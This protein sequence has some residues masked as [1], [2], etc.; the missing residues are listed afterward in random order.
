MKTCETKIYN[1]NEFVG[2]CGETAVAS[3]E[4]LTSIGGDKFEYKLYNF[5]HRCAE[6]IDDAEAHA[7]A[8]EFAG[9]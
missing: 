2:I 1:I 7:A 6:R 5:C 3:R 8:T 4:Q 9:E